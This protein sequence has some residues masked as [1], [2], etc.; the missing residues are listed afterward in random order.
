MKKLILL[1]A[2]LFLLFSCGNEKQIQETIYTGNYDAAIDMA[3]Q[4]IVKK[5]GKKSADTYVKLLK[6][7]Y[8]KAVARDNEILKK[9]QADVNPEKWQIIYDTYL[10]LDS[11]QEKIKP[12]LPLYI[13]K[14]G[15]KVHFDIKN[16]DKQIIDA[17]N[18][19]VAHLYKK[20]NILLKSGDKKKI[21]EAYDLLDEIDRIDPNYKDVRKLMDVA[22]RKGTT[23]ALVEIKN[24]T[25]KVIPRRLEDELLNFSSY[26]ASNF[27]VDYHNRPVRGL[28]YD[29]KINLIFTGID[30]S[31]DQQR[32]KEIIEEKEIQDGY[33]YQRDANG[34]IVKDSLGKAI[35]IPRMIRVRSRLKLY[36][37]YKEAQVRAKVE[38]IDNQT[39]R[40]LD[41]FPLQSK[42][43][44]DYR[45]ANSEGD[46]RAIRK[47]YIDFLDKR[48]VPFPSNEQMIYD[49]SKE[50][51]MQF[52]DILNKA[53]FL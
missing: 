4:Q 38:V 46:R 52:K 16:Y 25:D 40:K 15:E 32:E 18:H 23:Y 33:T 27:W 45:Y 36:Q 6:E 20:A 39:G 21:R 24:Q 43:I 35:K 49:A 48:P 28:K 7:S 41:D 17:K 8:D 10:N 14:T 53:N 37:Q 26:G 2:S 11:R 13:V 47:E 3:I 51:K 42:F 19:L 34:N 50:I 9:A 30:I 31:P 29:Y 1:F 5:K 44:F 22:H 12:L